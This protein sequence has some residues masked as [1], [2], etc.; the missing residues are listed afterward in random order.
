MSHY[1]YEAQRGG[2]SPVHANYLFGM[3]IDIDFYLPDKSGTPGGNLDLYGKEMHFKFSGDD[4]VWVFVD[5][6][7][8]LDLGGIHG[9]ESGDINFST[10]IVTVNGTID[11]N[12]TNALQT[13]SSGEHT[14]TMYYLE[15]G[16]SQSNCAIYFNLAPR[17]SFSIEKEDFL[18]RDVLNGAQFAVYTDRDCT[19][20]APD[21]WTSEAAHD[22]GEASTHIFTVE[23]G[24]AT[25]WGMCA[26]KTYYIKE[27]TPPDKKDENGDPIYSFSYGIICLTFDKIGTASYNVEM[28]GEGTDNNITN[29][30]TVHG[31]RIDEET[32]QA[33]IVATNAPEWAQDVTSVE[34][35][36][37]WEDDHSHSTE[38]VT[39]YLTVTD[40]DGTVRR[41]QE[42]QLSDANGWHHVWDNL[43]KYQDKDK[44]PAVYGVEESYVDGYYSK[45][46]DVTDEGSYTFTTTEWD[47]A[48]G[49]EEGKVYLL[50][51]GSGYLSTDQVADDTGFMWVDEE[52]AKTSPLARWTVEKSGSTYRMLKPMSD[53]EV[54]AMLKET[55]NGQ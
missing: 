8:V 18:T 23:N 40:P 54:F 44:T 5:D 27:I 38:A 36:K 35:R 37:V 6:T 16:S 39:V 41:L 47:T 42:A 31:F 50:K 10:G 21:L 30:F 2:E 52:T 9:I 48:S 29:G 17:F 3:S 49:F 51:T 34:V 25:M 4:D 55:D 22:A 43:L 28:I 24:A 46:E 19:D 13:I 26:G 20:P 32:Q 1:E 53:E 14:L 15:R 7:L 33:Y 12:L 11:Q 45:L